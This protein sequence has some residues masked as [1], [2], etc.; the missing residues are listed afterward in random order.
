MTNEEF[1]KN[2]EY[3]KTSF[4]KIIKFLN[5]C[6]KKIKQMCCGYCLECYNL[7]KIKKHECKM[8]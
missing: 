7:D 2:K 8:Y 1:I 6:S 3:Y 5:K 4:S